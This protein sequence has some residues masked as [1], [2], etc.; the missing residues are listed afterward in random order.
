MEVIAVNVMKCYELTD[1]R[2]VLCEA[3][4]HRIEIPRN[5]PYHPYGRFKHQNKDRQR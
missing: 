2:S 4:V 3:A 5:K 1:D